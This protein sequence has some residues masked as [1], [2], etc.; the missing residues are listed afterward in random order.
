VND[1]EL[2]KGTELMLRREEPE[3]KPKG[4]RFKRKISLRKKEFM[5]NIEF[6]WRGK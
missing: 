4:F 1:I 6:T 2:N 5:I 3:P